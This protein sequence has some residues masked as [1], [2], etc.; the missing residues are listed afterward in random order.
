MDK[1]RLSLELSTEIRDLS[2]KKFLITLSELS[3]DKSRLSLEL[4]TEIRD[5]SSETARDITDLITLSELA[6]KNHA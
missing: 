3:L 6:L 4:S 5:L 2:S 1:S